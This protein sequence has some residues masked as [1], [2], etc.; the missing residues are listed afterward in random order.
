MGSPRWLER[1]RE[2][3]REQVWHE[4]RQCGRRVREPDLAAEAQSVCDEMARRARRNLEVVVAR[5]TAQGYRFHTNDEAQEPVKAL[6][7]PGPDAPALVRWLEDTVG[8]MPMA[9]SS[10][11]RLVGDV[12]LVGTHPSWPQS[13]AADPLVIEL[14]GTRHPESSIRDYYQAELGE[15]EEWAAE[16][17]EAGGF[18]L[19][20]APDRLHKANISGG[21]PYGFRVPEATAE[22]PFVGEV[23]MPFVAYLNGVF[24]HGGFPGPAPGE[25]QWSVKRGLADGLLVL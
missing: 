17:P 22:G 23:A 21:E 14:E 9:L 5:L 15:W 20:V 25:H 11:V 3:R 12:W 8:D 7:P 10:W 19:P 2:G 13:T 4:L 24:R 1:Y 18:V 6:R 16:D